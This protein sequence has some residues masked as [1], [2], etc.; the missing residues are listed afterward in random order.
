MS[1]RLVSIDYTGPHLILVTGGD[2]YSISTKISKQKAF[3]R[4][5]TRQ[6]LLQTSPRA[7]RKGAKLTRVSSF[8]LLFIW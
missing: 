5:Y 1:N 7:K 4:Q 8:F 6:S 3:Y 2:S